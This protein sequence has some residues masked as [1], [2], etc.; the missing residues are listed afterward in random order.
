MLPS[1]IQH[2]AVIVGYLIF[3]HLSMNER[4]ASSAQ[5][6]SKNTLDADGCNQENGL[7]SAMRKNVWIIKYMINC[8]AII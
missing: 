5:M 7:K 6:D 1:S 2:P 4:V 8:Y 3:S